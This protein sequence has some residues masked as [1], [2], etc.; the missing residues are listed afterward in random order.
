[1]TYEMRQAYTEVYQ[2]LENMPKEYVNKI[3]QKVIEMLKSAE[4]ENYK[5]N[6]NKENPVDRTKLTR[7]AM[8]ILAIF[9]YQYWCPNRKVKNDLYK[10]YAKN[11]QKV[12]KEMQQNLNDLFKNKRKDTTQ[13]N[14]QVQ[15]Q[16]AMVE[17]K[18][19]IFAQIVNLL[20]KV[21]R[22]YRTKK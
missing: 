5:I 6:I 18:N 20:K 1:M 22:R 17:Y 11:E 14:V 9:N 2:V 13:N 16:V 15:N 7:Q 4:L 3:P 21:W 12:Q 10:I 8:I 19:S